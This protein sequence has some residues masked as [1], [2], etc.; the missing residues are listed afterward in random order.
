M[1]WGWRRCLT[2]ARTT[3]QLVRLNGETALRMSSGWWGL[4]GQEV[5]V[6]RAWGDSVVVGEA[7]ASK[8]KE[9]EK[10]EEKKKGVF[11]PREG[12]RGEREEKKKVG[13]RK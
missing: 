4:S 3:R 1:A 8:M 10:E 5:A 6:S 13:G 9:E 11:R 7:T 12:E 2:T